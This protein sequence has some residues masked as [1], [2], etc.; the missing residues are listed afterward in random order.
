M[1]RAGWPEIDPARRPTLRTARLTLRAPAAEDIP[2]L[3][4]AADD[5][6]VARWLARMPH[7]Y[8]EA[9]AHRFLD[10]VSPGEAVWAIRITRTGALAGTVGLKPVDEETGEL[11]YWLGRA[12]WGQGY[13]SEAA[14]A[15]V[16]HGFGSM[17]L[18]RLVA[19]A[20]ADNP[21][22]IN[23]LTK[24]GFRSR[25]QVMLDVAIL[26]RPALHEEMVLSR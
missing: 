15:V 11:G 3:V 21:R 17:G 25:G 12:A 20:L 2:D 16:D 26:G 8:T 13:G 1:S 23:V 7:P 24:L 4:A 22:S 5:Y 18:T 9:D 6:E 10:I 14:R 19:R